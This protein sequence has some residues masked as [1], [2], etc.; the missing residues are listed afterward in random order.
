MLDRGVEYF[1]KKQGNGDFKFPFF[2]IAEQLKKVDILFGNLETVISDKGNKI[3]S[4]Y[5]FRANPKAV[6]GLIFAGF[7]VLSAAN[8]H[9]FDYGRMAMEDSFKRLKNAGIDYVGAGL[10]EGEAKQGI[11]KEI[12]GTKVAFL[13][14]N[15][16]G[17][18]YWQATAE[19][20]G[21]NW[22]DGRIKEDIKKAKEKS[23]LVIVSMHF[24]EEYYKKP[25][26]EQEYFARLA[27]D[28][29]ADLV[30]GHHP[31]VVQPIEKYKN[32]WI[33]YS[34][35][36]FVFDQGFSQETMEGLLLEI[37]IENKKIKEVNPKKVKL[38]EFFQPYFDQ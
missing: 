36:N 10:N 35:G 38:S 19:R 16:K 23:D 18:Q 33:A 37:I 25:S 1:V 2:K 28:S 34:L 5:S 26:R 13:A 3:G 7:D 31:H 15:N 30:I 24:G 17:S 22:L 29:S 32:G 8:N 14:Y 27:I 9:V 6:E 11:I 20:S 21:I 12:K 4:I